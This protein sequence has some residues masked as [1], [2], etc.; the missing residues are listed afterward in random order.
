MQSFKDHYPF[1]TYRPGVEDLLEKLDQNQDKRYF[2]IRGRTGCH[3]P[4]TK[5]IMYDGTLR[6]VEDVKVGDA[7]MGPDSSK[8]EVLH[9][10][11]GQDEM[12]RV[13]PHKGGDSFVI[14]KGHVISLISTN[15]GASQKGK[16]FTGKEISDISVE[17][18]LAKSK[19]WKHLHKL[20]RAKVNFDVNLP[21][22]IQPY[23]LGL[24]LGD[25]SIDKRVAITT[26][27]EQIVEYAYEMAKHYGLTIREE[28]EQFTEC[29][30][31][32][33]TSG[34]SQKAKNTITAH[35]KKL[36]L[37]GSVS[38]SKFIPFAYK[39]SSLEDRLQLLAG[40]MDSDGSIS[41]NCFDY[42]SKSKA[43]A[44]DV[45]FVARSVGLC[46][47][48]GEKKVNDTTYYRLSISGDTDQIPCV[49][50]RKQGKSRRQI[51]RSHISGFTLTS[52]GTGQYH[53][54]M[55]DG[56][57]RYL[58]E[59]FT[60]THNSGKSGIAVSIS[61]KHSA[62]I[63]TATKLLQD[64][65]AGTALFNSEFVLKGKSNYT[66]SITGGATG[67]APCSSRKLLQI[68]R[69]KYN[70]QEKAPPELRQN[71]AKNNICE[72]YQKK[73]ALPFTSGGILNYDL[74]FSS[75][76]T[77]NAIV[78]DEAH[79]FIDKVLDFYSLE[80]PTKRIFTLLRIS[81]L[82]NQTNY[83]DWLKRVKAAA[84]MRVETSSDSKT[85]EQCKQVADRISA[86][87]QE[88]CLPGDFY[89]D[90]ANDKIQIKPIYP[91]TMAHKFL[92]RFKQI[93]FLSATIDVNFARILGLDPK[94]T[95]EFN[96]DS[97]FPTQNRPIYFPKDIP[98][99]NYGTKFSKDMP[100]VQ[101][102]DAV[103]DRHKGQRGIIHTSNYKVFSALQMIYGGNPRFTW[104]EQGANKSI[105]LSQHRLQED[106]ILV[107]PS[108]MEGVD[109][110]DD[111]ARFQV[112][113]KLPFPARSDYMEALNSA[114]PGLYEMATRNSLVQ[115]YGRAVRSEE[116]WAH[117]YVLDGS[118]RFMLESMDS[119]F[120]KAVKMGSWEKLKGA[121]QSGS[122][123]SDIQLSQ[124][125]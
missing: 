107:S 115:A 16:K 116:D 73:Y 95:I 52:I 21:L 19:K 66:C 27:D 106:S 35:L 37:Y 26:I 11:S 67:D 33:L 98:T 40:L 38:G 30:T 117:T 54:F 18:Y 45:A 103:L 123:G 125:K 108:M 13:T 104:V 55:L 29:K 112:I 51:K 14:N 68:A 118:L 57:H 48:C 44:D 53:G 5:V 72:Y 101:V 58:L 111:L 88:A 39:T 7:L 62:H 64:Q 87:L 56:D 105:A 3:S 1:P 122:I 80:I 25:G 84:A 63:L 46:V 102:L 49:L 113:M 119:Y 96:L 61:R 92:S 81:D 42:V 36:G 93:Y 12:Y 78:L 10:F 59:D 97:T 110:A 99:V 20:F 77:G 17:D 74:A 124:E 43:L 75:G 32:N 34:K 47:S 8:R 82:P 24:L 41:K 121:L 71:C 120:A 50:S 76:F 114:M 65:Y 60:V 109:L 94:D 90:T 15:V 22:L 9:L 69:T 83:V 4:G 79:N 23:F 28:A 100:A 85:R 91:A 70:L 86:I 6:K 89:V 2:I 31:Y